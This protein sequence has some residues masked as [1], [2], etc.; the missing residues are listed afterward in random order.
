MVVL[1]C[2]EAGKSSSTSNYF[3]AEGG[4][5]LFEVVVVVDLLVRVF[6]ITPTERHVDA[7][8]DGS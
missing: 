5:V 3:M 6:G 4:L 8:C 2:L 7:M 1:E